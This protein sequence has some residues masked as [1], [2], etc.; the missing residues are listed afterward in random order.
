MRQRS[1]V[2]FTLSCLFVTSVVTIATSKSG[3]Q[4]RYE[5]EPVQ[6]YLVASN[7][8]QSTSQQRITVTNEQI[9]YPMNLHFTDFGLPTTQLNP[10]T[11][12]QVFSMINGRQRSCSRSEMVDQGTPLIVYTCTENNMYIC[13]VTFELD[14]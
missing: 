10:A 9:S 3:D 14:Q 13:Q 5:P 1:K 7:C 8:P 2:V 6:N 4:G 11:T 12:T